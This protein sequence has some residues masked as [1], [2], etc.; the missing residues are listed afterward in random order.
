MEKNVI[1]L[2]V[3]FKIISHF[4]SISDLNWKTPIDLIHGSSQTAVLT[5]NEFDNVD[6]V[7]FMSV[8]RQTKYIFT[9]ELIPVS[10]R[11]EMNLQKDFSCLSLY[12]PIP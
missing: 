9:Q 1:S 2:R 8:D 12:E 7:F 3:I 10:N 6:R 4:G 11:D 5:S